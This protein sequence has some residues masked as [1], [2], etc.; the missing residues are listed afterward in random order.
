M[1]HL[2]TIRVL[3]QYEARRA[4]GVLITDEESEIPLPYFEI[5]KFYGC[6]YNVQGFNYERHDNASRMNVVCRFLEDRVLPNI[7]PTVDVSGSYKIE[8][9]DTIQTHKT[10]KDVGCFTFSR[11][12]Y[13]RY[14]YV[15]FPD[16]YQILGYGG[17]LDV[18]DNYKWS[19]KKSRALF[20][21]TTTGDTNPLKNERLQACDWVVRSIPRHADFYITK[22]AQMREQDVIDAY[23]LSY[24]TFRRMS[25][26]S[27][28]QHYTYKYLV[29]IAGNTCA[30]NRVPMIMN[31]RSL[32]LHVHHRDMTWYYPMLRENVHYAPV[33]MGDDSLVNTIQFYENNPLEAQ[34]ICRNA[35]TFV[36][37]YC[38]VPS[39]VLYMTM[40][41]EDIAFHHKK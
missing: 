3:A 16:E 18:V 17:M 7:D 41:L 29:N 5:K 15:L 11:D 27:I 4:K 34:V 21:G 32:M 40:L 9:H 33:K 31:S 25:Q 30:W 38:T 22:V 37:Q 39:A 20:C 2:D 6:G 28:P 13:S 23:P 24:P 26:I 14:D 8:L 12:R 36:K 19:Q 10:T 35:N 1:N